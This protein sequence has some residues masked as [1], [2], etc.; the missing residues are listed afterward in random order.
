M[1]TQEQ[2]DKL[3]RRIADCYAKAAT[4]TWNDYKQAYFQEARELHEQVDK[5]KDQERER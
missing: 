2:I 3:E 5:L 4:R 1:T